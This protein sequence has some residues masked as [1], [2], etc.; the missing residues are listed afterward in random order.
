MVQSPFSK[1]RLLHQFLTRLTTFSVW[2]NNGHGHNK[3]TFRPQLEF[4]PIPEAC[5]FNQ[6]LVLSSHQAIYGCFAH[7]CSSENHQRSYRVA[8]SSLQ[9]EPRLQAYQAGT[10]MQS[11]TEEVKMLIRLCCVRNQAGLQSRFRL[12]RGRSNFIV[13]FLW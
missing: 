2:Q 4:G 11:G 9:F 1:T 5:K 7:I 8:A 12:Q 3:C 6:D 10:N 13:P